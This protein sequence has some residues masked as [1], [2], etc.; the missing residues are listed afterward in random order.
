M[1]EKI[2]KFV[3]KMILPI[4]FVMIC[5]SIFRDYIDN[6]SYLYLLPIRIILL[7]GAISM[8]VS[9]IIKPTI[10]KR[11]KLHRGRNIKDFCY[12][13]SSIIIEKV[14]VW[15][16]SLYIILRLDKVSIIFSFT[17]LLVFGIFYGYRIANIVN[18]Y[19]KDRS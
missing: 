6:I 14:F 1:K 4:C 10:K 16:I 5:L 19:L 17:A 18:L 11:E 13:N 7:L 3:G 15:Y 8:I 2:V 9:S 12:L